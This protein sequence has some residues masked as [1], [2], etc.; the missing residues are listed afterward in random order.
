[1]FNRKKDTPDSIEPLIT[2]AYSKLENLDPDSKEYARIIKQIEKLETIRS[3]KNKKDRLF[4]PD[5][6][7][8]VGANLLGILLVLNYEKAD[9]VTSKAMGLVSKT[10]L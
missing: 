6:L 1:M 5:T 2:S 10:K 4:S 3:R 8:L 9:V 7:L